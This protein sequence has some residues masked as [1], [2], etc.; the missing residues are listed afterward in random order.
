MRTKR[1]LSVVMFDV[2]HF[3]SIDDE[4][5]DDEFLVILPETPMRGSEHEPGLRRSS[6]QLVAEAA[7]RCVSP[8]F[9]AAR[10]AL[11]FPVLRVIQS[12]S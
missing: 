11:G 5:G 2:D 10:F 3:K 9:R 12:T 1:P 4:Y 6:T 7:Y 8:D